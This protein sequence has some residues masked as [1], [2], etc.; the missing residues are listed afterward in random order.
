MHASD[1]I[2]ITHRSSLEGW[3]G[4]DNEEEDSY[5]FFLLKRTMTHTAIVFGDNGHGWARRVERK[6]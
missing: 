6:K 2:N 3:E 1:Q 4:R 5:P